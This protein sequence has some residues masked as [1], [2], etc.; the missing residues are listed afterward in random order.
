MRRFLLAGVRRW[1]RWT[2][3]PEAESFLLDDEWC[4]PLFVPD[5]GDVHEI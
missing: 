5:A 4:L 1:V 3:G 2:C